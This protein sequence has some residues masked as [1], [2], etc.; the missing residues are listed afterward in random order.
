M[1]LPKQF[2]GSAPAPISRVLLLYRDLTVDGVVV[3]HGRR[4]AHHGRRFC[5]LHGSPAAPTATTTAT[6][7]TSDGYMSDED[8]VEGLDRTTE[9]EADRRPDI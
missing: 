9:T 1:P 3:R 8:L 5:R 2:S 4:V 7:D 6:T